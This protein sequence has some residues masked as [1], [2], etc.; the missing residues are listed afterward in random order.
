MN[1]LSAGWPYILA[2]VFAAFAVR[3]FMAANYPTA[4]GLIAVAAVIAALRWFGQRSS[5]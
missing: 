3:A 4:V 5:S 2:L 1:A